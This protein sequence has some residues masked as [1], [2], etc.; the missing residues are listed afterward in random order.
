MTPKDAGR[1]NNIIICEY[2]FEER[3]N[4]FCAVCTL[5]ISMIRKHCAAD[6]YS[7]RNAMQTISEINTCL[8]AWIAIFNPKPIKFLNRTIQRKIARLFPSVTG[9]KKDT[10]DWIV[11]C[12]KLPRRSLSTEMLLSP[13]LNVLFMR[14]TTFAIF[15][16]YDPK[17]RPLLHFCQI[18]I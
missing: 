16:E 1:V 9:D 5:Q 13:Q 18:P 12:Y 6:D 17:M 8:N 4:H 2:K 11:C 14:A 7:Q 10:K 15:A 3:K